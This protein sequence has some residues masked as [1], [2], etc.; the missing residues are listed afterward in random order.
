MEEPTGRADAVGDAPAADDAQRV[1]VPD[2]MT[3]AWERGRDWR[4]KG[5]AR[6][7]VPMEYRDEDHQREA[8]AWQAG[9]DGKPMPAQ[10]EIGL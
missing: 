5:N 2:T 8:A 10:Q 7:A 1:P 6:K 3:T 9:F 4:A